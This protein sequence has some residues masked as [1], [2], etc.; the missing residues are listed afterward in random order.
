MTTATGVVCPNC[1]YREGAA[2][3]NFCSRC[4]AALRGPPC[5][6]CAAPSEVGDRF[7]IRCGTGL[8]AARPTLGIKH[9][10]ASWVATGVLAMALLVV[11]VVRLTPGVEMPPPPTLPGTLGPTSAVPLSSMTP[12]QAA[13]RLSDRVMRSVASGDQTQ[14]ELFLPM[15]IASYDL[16]A[17]LTLDDRFHL[18]ML[19]ATAGD[20]VSALAVAE[21]GLAVRPTHLLCLAAAARAALLDGGADKALAYYQTLVNVYDEEIGAGLQEYDPRAEEGH[22]ELLP[23][24]RREASDY[25]AGSR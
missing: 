6:A 4:G 13:T 20:A 3:S 25:L 11:L 21:A 1:R 18:S 24:L 16:I 23:L 7:C 10:R 5:P 15:A 14:V 22:A 9:A 19:H 12:R 2:D 8:T 17:A